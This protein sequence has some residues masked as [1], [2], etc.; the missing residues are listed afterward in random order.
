M[1][2][3]NTHFPL[4]LI[5]L[6]LLYW[7]AYGQT[8][9]FGRNKVH[10]TRFDWQV[11]QTK[12]FDIYY[13]PEMKTLSE[14]GAQIAEDSYKVLQAKFNFSVTRRIPLIFYSSHSHF[15]QTNVTPGFIPEGVGGF[16]EFFKGRVVIPGNGD[17]NQFKHVIRHELVHVFMHSK[18]NNISRK[19]DVFE[20]AYPPLWYVEGLAEFW[21]SQ[22]DAQ[23]EMVLKDAVLNNYV[24]GLQDMYK[25]NGT[26]AMYKIGQNALMYIASR[27]GEDKVLDLMEELWKYHKFEECF[28]AVIGLDYKEFDAEYLHHLKKKYYPL[29]ARQDF[30]V[31]TDATIVRDG[32]SFKPCYYH[33]SA[34]DFVVFTGNRSGYSSIYMR[35]LQ[36]LGLEDDEDETLLVKGEASADFEAF[37]LFQSRISVTQNGLL[38]FSAKS[39]AADVLYLYDIPGRKLIEK[40]R[41]KDIAAIYSPA[42]SPDGHQIIFSG[43]TLEG[44]IDLFLYDRQARRLDRLTDDFYNDQD[45]AFSPDGR[46]IAFASDRTDYGAQNA[47]NLFLM[48]VHSGQ[49]YYLTYGRQHDRAPAFSADGKK[50]VYTSDLSGTDNLYLIEN[51]VQDAHSNR[52]VRFYQVTHSVG[53]T[54]DPCW[55]PAGELLYGTFEN[56]RFQIRLKT[57]IAAD[58]LKSASRSLIPLSRQHW[59]TPGIRQSHVEARKPYVKKF[60]LD[61]AQAQMSQD[62]IFGTT[63]GAQFA[64]T[65]MLND[66]QYYVFIYNN[67]QTSSDLWRSFNFM[68]SKLSLGQRLNYALSLYRFAGYYYNP[69]D[70]YYYEETVGGMASLLYPLSQFSRLSLTQNFSYSDKDWFFAKRRRAWLNSSFV[71]F[72]F[73]NSLFGYT[74]PMDGQR[75]N[76]TFG[77]TYDFAFARVNYLTGLID[78][79]KYFRLSLRNTYAVRFM[80]L[81]SEGREARQF[82]FG[83]SWDLRLYPRWQMHG[84]RILLF[85]QELR[86][87]LIDRLTFQLPIGAMTFG[88]IRGALF[89]DAGNTWNDQWTGLKGSFGFGVR[90]RLGN[91]LVLRYDYGR[92]TDFKSISSKWYGQFFFGW[93]F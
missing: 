55:T 75:I 61:F 25:I 88:G 85:S 6:L 40:Q 91:F 59:M 84:R 5:V 45:A 41:F 28:K 71:S 47:T 73:D 11:L 7:I 8:M 12:H 39:G 3:T 70:A 18:L 4:Y 92:R 76:I 27:F 58:S 21:S 69:A 31:I 36:P 57:N 20:M 83:G 74:G 82:Y 51:P 24:V 68:I 62:P 43:L 15:E 46:Y 19:H 29:L 86:F 38:A 22:W 64:F 67:A 16:F 87:P 23:G 26:F 10:Y 93:D 89:A 17:M 37:H 49:I 44:K 56:G 34:G 65:D 63:G 2:K 32:Y 60:T 52:P 9:R 35:P 54:F 90:M 66:D 72:V 80:S 33:S 81:F 50:L 13:Y 77:N 48:D 79:R 1:Q 42:L 53:S 78:L 30:N 14:K